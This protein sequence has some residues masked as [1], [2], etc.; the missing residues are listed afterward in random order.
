METL[1]AQNIRY[2][3]LIKMYFMRARCFMRNLQIA[4][5]AWNVVRRQWKVE[6]VLLGLACVC[7]C[8]DCVPRV[9]P[10]D[11]RSDCLENR[12]CIAQAFI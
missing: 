8:F 6:S 1:G 2:E 12:V 11:N 10:G 3:L 7:N 4:R 9:A 5:E